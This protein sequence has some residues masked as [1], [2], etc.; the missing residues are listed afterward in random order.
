MLEQIIHD[1]SIATLL[2]AL[3]TAVAVGYRVTCSRDDQSL[4]ELAEVVSISAGCLTT[5]T[6]GLALLLNHGGVQAFIDAVSLS[7]LI[8]GVSN[9]N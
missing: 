7:P 8:N 5:V 4:C 1:L 3:V 2:A 9:V 6:G